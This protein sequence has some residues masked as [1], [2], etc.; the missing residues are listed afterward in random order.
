VGIYEDVGKIGGGWV[1]GNKI[2]DGGVV[3]SYYT[4]VEMEAIE[5]LKVFNYICIC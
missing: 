1:M 4:K 5:S 3:G 2:L